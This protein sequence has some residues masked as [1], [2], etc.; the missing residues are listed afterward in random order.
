[1]SVLFFSDVHGSEAALQI[2][3][4]RI[5][6]FAPTHLALLGDCLDRGR[7]SLQPGYNP[8]G[9]AAILNR[10]KNRIVAVRGNCDAD[11]DQELLDSQSKL[12]VLRYKS[13]ITKSCS[14]TV[15]AGTQPTCHRSARLTSSP[16]DIPM[17]PTCNGCPRGSFASIPAPSP[18]PVAAIPSALAG[19]MATACRSETCMNLT[20][21]SKNS[22]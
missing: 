9:A 22:R 14:P 1:M 21:F 12:S 20:K 8:I 19:S 15:H 2:L 17:F 7:N 10:W 5:D 16:M 13:I 18:S 4:H 3:A 11:T 6:E